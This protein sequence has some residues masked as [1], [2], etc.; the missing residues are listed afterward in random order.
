MQPLERLR[1]ADVGKEGGPSAMGYLLSS[2]GV[3]EVDKAVSIELGCFHTIG[4]GRRRHVVR[5]REYPYTIAHR[6]AAKSHSLLI[7]EGAFDR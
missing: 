5:E 7:P 4:P 2:S 6:S 3:V 1:Y